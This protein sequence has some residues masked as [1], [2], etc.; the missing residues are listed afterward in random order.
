MTWTPLESLIHVLKNAYSGELAA[1]FAYEGHRKS[2]RS[3]SEKAEIEVIRLQELH[4][5]ERVGQ[6]L[7]ML[8]AQPCRKRERKFTF[9]GKLISLLCHLGGWFLPMF[10]AGKLENSNII[11]YENAARYALAADHI[12]MVDDLL[13]MAEVEWDHEKYFRQKIEGHWMCRIVRLW[14]PP[15]PKQT[16]RNG[17]GPLPDSQWRAL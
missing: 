8:G 15:P 1:A 4:H 10:G 13:Q 2:V 17:Y 14:P 6:F 7:V 3:Q 5:R 9:I 16:I 11:E 12:E